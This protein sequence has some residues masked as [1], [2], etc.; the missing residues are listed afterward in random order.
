VKPTPQIFRWS[1]RRS[2]SSGQVFR[3]LNAAKIRLVT[4]GSRLRPDHIP[5][6]RWPLIAMAAGPS[7]PRWKHDGFYD[8]RPLSGPWSH[9]HYEKFAHLCKPTPMVHFGSS[10]CPLRVTH[11]SQFNSARTSSPNIKSA[12]FGHFATPPEERALVRVAPSCSGRRI[13]VSSNAN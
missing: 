3:P 10:R 11:A 4:A 1:V 6:P 9:A 8:G 13:D 7:C 12:A 2:R 5:A